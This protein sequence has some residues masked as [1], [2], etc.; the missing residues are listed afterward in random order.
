MRSYWRD[1]FSQ[2]PALF[3]D[4]Y[5]R[6]R[7]CLQRAHKW[8]TEDTLAVSLWRYGVMEEWLEKANLGSINQTALVEI[9]KEITCADL[10]AFIARHYLQGSVCY[11]ELGVSVGKNIWQV[12]NQTSGATLVGLDIE[13]INP[14]LLAYFD[15]VEETWRGDEVYPVKTFTKGTV[16]KRTTSL[17]LTSGVNV[18]EY[19]SGDKF[20]SDTWAK[21]AGRRFNLIFSD[22]AHNPESLH[23]EINFLMQ[24]NLIDTDKFF[25]LWDDL[26]DYG[27]QRA[28]EQSAKALCGMFGRDDKAVAMYMIHGSYGPRRRM[29]LFSSIDRDLAS[30][31]QTS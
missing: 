26:F 17:R 7:D 12:Y 23:S 21:L 27:M 15:K 8:V 31:A 22:A 18:F 16:E 1:W 29:G 28:F 3:A 19:I 24:H 6:N 11:L 14:A 9:E 13:E 4:V 5:T 2:D 25:M 10:L 20:R 30:N